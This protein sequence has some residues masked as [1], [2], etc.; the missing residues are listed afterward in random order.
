MKFLTI[1]FSLLLTVQIFAKD[2]TQQT[3]SPL[4]E[5]SPMNSPVKEDKAKFL[6]TVPSGFEIDKAKYKIKNS[7]HIFD[8]SDK[9]DNLNLTKQGNDYV[10]SAD[11]SKLPP[12]QY[13][14]F[15]KIVDKKTKKEHDSHQKKKHVLKDFAAFI[16]DETMQVPAP[17]PKKDALT[18]A[19]IDSDNDGLPDRTQRWINSSSY[20]I[21]M[22]QALKNSGRLLQTVILNH[23]NPTN[24]VV[25]L[26]SFISASYCIS[27][28]FGRGLENLDKSHALQDELQQNMLN[29]NERLVAYRLANTHASGTGGS[30]PQDKSKEALCNY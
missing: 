3:S 14:F 10:A 25:A 27:A 17:D 22:K 11:V 21:D 2:K 19:G 18:L 15:L 30:I 6:V 28:Q 5:V 12:G 4:I 20:S 13:Q 23:T 8:K 24:S 16:I 1:S 26:D 7:T 29:T 9:H